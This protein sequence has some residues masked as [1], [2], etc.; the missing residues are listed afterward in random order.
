MP[1]ISRATT[2]AL[3]RRLGA[4]TP[5][6]IVEAALN[7]GEGLRAGVLSSFGAEAAVL[8]SFVARVAPQTPVI[9]LDTGMHFLQTLSYR[10]QLARHFGLT[11]L[12]ILTPSDAERIE[13]DPMGALW[14]SDTDA[15]CDLRKT[16]PLDR[17][18]ADIDLVITGRKRHQT[19]ERATMQAFELFGGRIRA[20]P[21]MNWSAEQIEARFEAEGLPRHPLTEHGYPSIGCWPCTRSV[22]ADEDKRAGRWSGATK[23]ECGI[24]L[25][26]R[27]VAAH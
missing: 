26:R 13:E 8:L 16:R 10:D 6:A 19:A 5:E 18:L 17:A 20:N 1:D 24:H 3:N 14:R 27:P 4:G 12:R 23:T 22:E 7:P 9:F 11:N 21:L 2:E 25:D 15:C